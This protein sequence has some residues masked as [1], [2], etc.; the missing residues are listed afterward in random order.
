MGA[1]V[2]AALDFAQE[3][4]AGGRANPAAEQI[5]QLGE[6]ER[7]EQK[8]RRRLGQA[9]DGLGVPVLTAVQC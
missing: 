5:V 6:N 7:R 3:A 8:R 9:H 4:G 1:S 2:Y